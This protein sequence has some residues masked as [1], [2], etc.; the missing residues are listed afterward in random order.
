LEKLPEDYQEQVEAADS[1]MLLVWSERV[2]T[3][4]S[5]RE[6]FENQ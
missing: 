2:L 6:I 4:N 3:G 5:L 1:E